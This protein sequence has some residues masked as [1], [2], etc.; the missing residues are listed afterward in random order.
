M[1]SLQ[2]ENIL[3]ELIYVKKEMPEVLYREEIIDGK[4][5]SVIFDAVNKELYQLKGNSSR[6]W[7]LI[8]GESSMKMIAARLRDMTEAID[9]KQLLQDVIRFV[10]KLGRLK[11]IKFAYKR[12]TTMEDRHATSQEI[13]S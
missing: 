9:D 3:D 12:S 10:V 1:A 6:I 13:T 8:D 7:Q 11:L 2:K 4:P 5:V